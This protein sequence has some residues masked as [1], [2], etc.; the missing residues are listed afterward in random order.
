MKQKNYSFA[1]TGPIILALG[2]VVAFGIPILI[3][4]MATV[5]KYIKIINTPVTP[6]SVPVW[7]IFVIGL[8]VLMLIKRRKAVQYV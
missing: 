4:G 1:F 6:G 2:A 8:I 3:G 7:A 5:I